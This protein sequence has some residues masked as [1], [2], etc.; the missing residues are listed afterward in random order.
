MPL[1]RATNFVSVK[2]SVED[3]SE[4]SKIPLIFYPHGCKIVNLFQKL[5]FEKRKPRHPTCPENS[6][7][8]VG[9]S[10]S[11]LWAVRHYYSHGSASLSKHPTETR[12]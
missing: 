6:F 2:M 8:R 10:L 5:S 3:L 7:L 11:A 12:L 4:I 1:H 9:L